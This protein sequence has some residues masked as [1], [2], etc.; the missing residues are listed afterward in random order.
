VTLEGYAL[1]VR[2]DCQGKPNAAKKPNPAKASMVG[3]ASHR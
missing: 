2:S 1:L 3:N